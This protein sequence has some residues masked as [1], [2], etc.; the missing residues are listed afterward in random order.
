VRL[1]PLVPCLWSLAFSALLTATAGAQAPPV[2]DDT[3]EGQIGEAG[4]PEDSTAAAEEDSTTN[5]GS[6]SSATEDQ[7]SDPAEDEP[8]AADEAGSSEETPGAEAAAADPESSASSAEDEVALQADET[9]GPEGGAGSA[10]EA[11]AQGEEP[12][13]ARTRSALR[14]GAV[15]SEF[16]LDG[17][18]DDP[19]WTT[20]DS[21]ENL[22]T[23][24]PEEGERPAGRT[25]AKVLVTPSELII[26]I[27]C[28][29]KRPKRIVSFS[30]ARDAE[31]EEEDHVLVVL[32]PFRDGRSGYVFM[33]NPSGAR[34]DG[35]VST[36][37]PDEFN[38]N[39]DAL[40]EAKTSRSAR[41]WSAEIRIPV[42]SLSFKRGLTSWGFNIQ[43]KIQRLQEVS[44]WSG[45]SQDYEV[46]QTSRAGLLT[47]LPT[48]D[49]GV[50][51]TVR[52]AL[53]AGA[54][55]LSPE[56]D[57]EYDGDVSLDVSQ[58]IG[59]NVVASATVNTDFA[60]TEVDARQTNLTRFDL[61]FPE[62]RP[63]FL[64][65][66]D[67][68]EFGVGMDEEIFVPFFTRRIGLVGEE[69]ELQQIPITAGGKVNGRMGN[70]NFSALT[71]R[72]GAE[73][74]LGLDATT[75]GAVR[76]KQNVLSESSVGML[77]T[78]GDPLGRSDSWMA[79]A[80]ATFQT[81]NF[82]GEKNFLVG[83]W[84]LRNDRA[85]LVEGGKSAYGGQIAFPND[86]IDVGA[87]V[88]H[89]D[90]S[91]EPS[92]GFVPRTGTFLEAGGEINPRPRWSLVHQMVH[93]F[94]YFAVFGHDKEIESHRFTIKPFDWLLS[95]GDRFEFIVQPE[96]ERLV[97]PFD[98]AG[99]VVIPTG[100]YNWI[101]YSAGAFTAPKRP[102]SG[103]VIFTFGDFYRG[104]LNTL[105]LLA[106]VE[107][108]TAFGLEFGV[109]RNSGNLPEGEF[110]EA[111]Y[112]G[113]VEFRYSSDLQLSSLL[114]YDNESESLGTNT[115]LRWTFHPLGDLFVVFN[116]NLAKT[117]NDRFRF[118]SNELL[119][120]LQYALRM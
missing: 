96:G 37:T 10:G 69:D 30:K 25:M 8:A 28:Y 110:V 81:S 58:R 38:R 86:L 41:G 7:A 45:A 6:D 55:R 62:K 115:R 35:L 27:M 12:V 82:M 67:I 21:I 54:N 49:Y 113:R 111:V 85:D 112:S 99:D 52:P 2:Q 103:S 57:R 32:D 70:T 76:L 98:I 71:V 51:L 44:R 36:Q 5:A 88:M 89:F 87:K 73:D 14:A 24:E 13:A 68:F 80:D 84:G 83:A 3:A 105:E 48:F 17:Q 20:A 39:W 77:A 104:N 100:S 93:E 95:S 47:E 78:F 117:I 65:G 107:P 42:K 33:V 29:D 120:K 97:E 15:S 46:F 63:F 26:G 116:H 66:A 106:K 4:A 40:W 56:V 109:E 114:Q 1:K 75:M 60:E 90:E 119:V 102:I 101:R 59:P 64:E 9:G 34:V 61:F 94:T 118:D 18:L 16:R 108:S 22:T 53:V 74:N 72:T 31:L 43:R 11:G 50:G 79:G 92:L 19:A 23:V 91:F